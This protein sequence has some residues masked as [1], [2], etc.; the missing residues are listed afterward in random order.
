MLLVREMA[1]GQLLDVTREVK[2]DHDNVRDLFARFQSTND[3]TMKTAIANTF[4]RE[5]EIHNDAEDI[6][7]YKYYET[8]GM[9]DMAS[10]NKAKHMKVREYA[11]RVEETPL[12]EEY[13]RALEKAFR[14][15]NDHAQ[16]E[17][18]RQHPL[19]KEKL[20][21]EDN[22]KIARS[23]LKARKTVAPRPRPLT[24]QMTNVAEKAQELRGRAHSEVGEEPTNRMFVDVKHAHPAV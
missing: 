3:R 20:S 5:M 16:D 19:L 17:E 15:F 14:V 2:F 21:A 9:G 22:D 8:A 1:S 6:S 12:S 10:Q 11:L 23:F 4:V 7:V 24:P 18:Q 13:D